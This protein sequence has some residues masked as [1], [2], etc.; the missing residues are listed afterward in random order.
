MS[1]N[2]SNRLNRLISGAEIRREL[3]D[4]RRT[5]LEKTVPMDE[6]DRYLTLG[7]EVVRHNKRTVRIRKSK[8]ADQQL[9]DEIWTLLALMGFQDI[10]SGRH[11]KMPIGGSDANMP[12]KQIDVLAI[13]GET[14]L[15]VECKSSD[16]MRR[17]SLQK[18]LNETRGLQ[19]GVRTT[20]HDN[21]HGRPRVCFVYA[22]RNIRWSKQDQERAK[23]HHIS[24]LRDRQIS[25]YRTLLNII[26]PA[27][28]HQLQ[29]DLLEGSPIQGLR[30][31]V[32]AL[33]G[34]FGSK[35][36]YQFAIEP[37]RLLK[38]AYISHRAKI[39]RE[40]LGTYQRLLR[41]K[42]LKDISGHI[43]ETGRVFPTNV[44]VN[45][46]QSRGL[47]FDPSGPSED[48]PTVLGTLHLPNTYKSA[49]VI[50]GQHRLYGFSLSDWADRG[51]VPVLAFENLEPSEEV[52]MFVEINNKQVKVPR[53]LL[54]ELEP[55]LQ[56]SDDRPEQRLSS[57]HSQ[58]AIDLSE[59][60]SSPLWDRVASEW[61]TDSI[62]RPVTLPQLATAI[63]GSQLVGSVRGGVLHP[64]F[65]FQRDWETTQ[66]RTTSVLEK[67]LT[68][69]A[70]GTP[71]H[72]LRERSSG[73]FL[74][75]NLGIA[76]LLRMFHAVLVYIKENRAN[77]EYDRLSPDAIVGLTADLVNIVVDWFNNAGDSDLTIFR[78]RY[79]SGAPIAYGFALME[80]INRTNA[81]FSP[82][83]LSEYIEEHSNESLSHARELITEIEDDI[84]NMTIAILKNKYPEAPQSWWREGVPQSVRGNAAQRAE[85]SEEG[86]EPHQ[87][88]DLIDYKRIAEQSKNWGDF[89]GRF[90]VDRS[91][92]SKSARL[93]WM[94]RLNTIR[95]RVSHSGR[96][97]VT[98][99]EIVFLEDVWFHVDE[100]WEEMSASNAP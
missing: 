57:L 63:S 46:R 15:V 89:E 37:D 51:R 6:E 22:T 66:S 64:G 62:N 86:G 45:F 78:G 93:S 25:Y 26:G 68:V 49:W 77:I 2:S 76:A 32:P 54:T 70:E 29:A 9:E 58:V 69:F 60:D 10:S 91:A 38:L 21:F 27:A 81:G 74:C 30:A 20:I 75:T 35:T 53:S 56:V 96:R 100:Q 67:F 97:H 84:R 43:N 99:E 12:P 39:D 94:D 23:A 48:D 80:V 18:D 65:L 17:R 73:G 44:V 79:G 50:D 95:N 55:E 42:R 52:R 41:K 85:T 19:D 87:F 24:I 14:A 8:P 33:R 82:P 40:S 98:S 16:T 59:S 5:V 31:T 72:W 13:D 90:T 71:D 1:A 36:F 92:R 88:L 61:D 3:R 4:R 47:R 83:G 11:F 28:R 34:R 7:W